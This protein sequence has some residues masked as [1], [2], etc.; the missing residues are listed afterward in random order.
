MK[1]K[2]FL[3]V[4]VLAALCGC[5]TEVVNGGVC[6]D[7]PTCEK[8]ITFDV[9][10][11]GWD[12]VTRA[13]TADG[14]DMSDLWLF[15]YVDGTLVRSLHKQ[16]GDVDFDAP[17]MIMAYGE[18]TVYFV[19]SR[20]K[21]PTVN[22]TGITWQQPS[23]TFWKSLSLVVS[24]GTS[25]SQSVVL[26]RVATRL[27]IV[28]SDAVPMDAAQLVV[29]PSQ[30]WYGVDYTTG[31]AIGEQ[32][33]ERTI[34]IPASYAGTT[35]Q[36]VVSIFGLSDADEWM[37]DVAI[38][39]KNGDGDV[40]GGVSLGDVPFKRNRTT[41]ATGSLF[42]SQQSLSVSLNDEWAEDYNLEW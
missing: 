17:S 30:W 19:A 14:Q 39:T 27:R 5:T 22:G 28:V 42:A 36:L 13:L 8:C 12:V 33:T 21:T 29:K 3:V 11:G 7:A 23:D 41:V 9:K 4:S 24:S 31:A 1:R 2:G 6:D 38:S 15:D 25:K 32:Q 16:Q 35:G 34:S 10:S 37:A 40:I 20:G 18:H 26:D